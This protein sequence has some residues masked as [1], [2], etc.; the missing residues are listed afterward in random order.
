MYAKQLTS[1]QSAHIFSPIIMSQAWPIITLREQQR[2][3]DQAF[4]KRFNIMEQQR[5][6]LSV[7]MV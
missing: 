2:S 1:T 3:Q 6:L 5:Y 7:E 4:R